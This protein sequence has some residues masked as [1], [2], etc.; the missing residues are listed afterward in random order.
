MKPLDAG[1]FPPPALMPAAGQAARSPTPAFSGRKPIGPLKT[2]Q[3]AKTDRAAK[4]ERA[5]K[6]DRVAKNRSGR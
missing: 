3:A 2:D 4:T 1:D 6:T 5:A